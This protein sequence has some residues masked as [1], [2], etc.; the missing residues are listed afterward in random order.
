MGNHMGE[1]IQLILTNGPS[2]KEEEFLLSHV[3]LIC[4]FRQTHREFQKETDRV[5]REEKEEEKSTL[6]IEI[7]KSENF[8]DNEL[9]IDRVDLRLVIDYVVA[10]DLD[11][12]LKEFFGQV[13]ER[14]K[15]MGERKKPKKR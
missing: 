15:E 11:G 4:L 8:G 2:S 1:K 12:K 5:K 3:R 10:L 6:N 14:I 13:E 7:V 9:G